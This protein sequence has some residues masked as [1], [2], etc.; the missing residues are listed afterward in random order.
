MVC[1][2]HAYLRGTGARRTGVDHL[3]CCS[4]LHG[5]SVL[6]QPLL[7]LHRLR[8]PNKPH[9]APGDRNPC[10]TAPPDDAAPPEAVTSVRWNADA[11]PPT[12]AHSY[13]RKSGIMHPRDGR[14]PPT[15]DPQDRGYDV[16]SK[17]RG[18]D[19]PLFRGPT[20]PESL[21]S[22]VLAAL[23][24]LFLDRGALWA[25]EKVRQKLI[26]DSPGTELPRFLTCFL[27]VRQET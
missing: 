7:D 13:T 10:L 4:A 9:A 20:L 11:P 17:N 26:Q 25:E 2:H 16:C 24:S 3:N 12:H 18:R 22:S 23:S 21:G 15:G 5:S 6:S 27:P 8:T 19:L 1:P 14:C